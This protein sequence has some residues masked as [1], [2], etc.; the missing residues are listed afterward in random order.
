MAADGSHPRQLTNTPDIVELGPA[1]SPD[2]KQI[3]FSEGSASEALGLWVMNADGSGLR[4]LTPEGFDPAWS[5]DGKTIAYEVD[6][7]TPNNDILNI[8]VIP[9][10]GGE[11][12]NLTPGATY[13]VG[14]DWS[15]GGR[16]IVFQLHT[17]LAV[18]KADGSN[19]HRITHDGGNVGDGAP[20]WSPDGRWI[21]YSRGKSA[22]DT[23]DLYVIHPDGNDRHRVTRRGNA[24]APNWQRR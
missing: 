11:P 23:A 9:A 19:Q 20:A 14:P 1:W 7:S 15:P 22:D 8:Y 6:K 10:A 12:T 13:A 21:V 24:G 16:R 4:Q 5:P 3:V 17:D 2:G 18:M